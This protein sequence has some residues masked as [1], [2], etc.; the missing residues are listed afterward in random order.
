MGRRR[1]KRE[2]KKRALIDAKRGEE[3][4]EANKGCAQTDEVL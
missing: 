4:E 1:E 3:R 2:E